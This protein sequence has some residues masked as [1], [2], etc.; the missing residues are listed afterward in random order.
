MRTL[1]I[2][3]F[4]PLHL[5]EIELPPRWSSEEIHTLR[6][7]IGAVY[8]RGPSYTAFY[9]ERVIGCGGVHEFWPGVGEGWAVFCVRIGEF[10][11]ELL[12]YSREYLDVIMDEGNFR[13]VQATAQAA[14]PEACSFL[15]RLGF[16][17]EGTL[18]GY[19]P[20]GEDHIMYARVKGG[21]DVR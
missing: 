3:P 19:G 15:E 7:T 1:K 2:E 10:K 21:Q 13:R 9:E 5:V 18:R 12:R 14:W 16:V 11:R 17:R 8:Q 20:E 6:R 4:Q